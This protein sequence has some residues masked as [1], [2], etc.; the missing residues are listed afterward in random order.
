MADADD[1]VV[2]QKPINRA[3]QNGDGVGE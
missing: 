1:V 2:L 3:I